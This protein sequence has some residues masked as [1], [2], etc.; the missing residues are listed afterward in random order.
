MK[1]KH[2]AIAV[3]LLA[4]VAGGVWRFASRDT[5]TAFAPGEA[6]AGK[7]LVDA[8]VLNDTT[9]IEV[10]ERNG[11]S[12]AMIEEGKQWVLPE[13]YGIPVRFQKL[14]DFTRTL[15]EAKVDRFVTSNPERLER[16]DLG[17]ATV[18]LKATGGDVLWEMQVGESGPAGGHFIGLKDHEG[19]FLTSTRFFVDT[20]P[21]NW[22]VKKPLDIDPDDISGVTIH[23]PDE[24][25]LRLVRSEPGGEFSAGDLDDGETLDR[26][27]INRSLQSLVD[28]TYRE[29]LPN[30]D[31]DV[32][33]ARENARRL[34]LT[35]FDG[36]DYNI[37][38]GR[39]PGDPAA[40]VAA[41]DPAPAR[42]PDRPATV[43]SSIIF[44]QDGNIVDEADLPVPVAEVEAEVADSPGGIAAEGGEAEAEED[45]P[46]REPGPVFVFYESNAPD[47]IWSDP[48]S[49][50]SLQF[51]DHV[52]ED[53][54]AS[55]SELIR[56]PGDSPRNE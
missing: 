51:A 44:D 21:A 47:F 9:W 5:A 6:L 12:V 41:P 49:R 40:V 32:V 18:S 4:V 13:Y 11:P 56:N 15:R 26:S 34:T 35:T 29:I 10:S 30:D 3:A 38:I 1:L 22:A 31:P 52:L 54:P 23:F 37:A 25:R 28:A 19:A 55:R 7:S 45:D 20:T 2:L 48:L 39:R 14:A 53:F 16:L 46:G 27:R 42:E 24:T 43:S 36:Y 33:G 17:Q 50:I 8:G